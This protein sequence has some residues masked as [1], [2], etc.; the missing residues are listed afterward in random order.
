MAGAA[1]A[2][3]GA[4]GH[5]ASGGGGGGGHADAAADAPRDAGTPDAA[6]APVTIYTIVLSQT[7]YAE[8]VGNSKA[9]YLNSLIAA[10]GLATNYM[11][12]GHPTVPNRL[13]MISGSTQ[14]PGSPTSIQ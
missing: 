8:I 11:D 4:A 7:D 5:A 3:A 12:N 14:Y 10:Y 2:T 1:G 6:P 13:E 9:P